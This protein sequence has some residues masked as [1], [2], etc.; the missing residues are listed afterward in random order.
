MFA[1]RQD[2]AFGPVSKRKLLSAYHFR[3]KLV[4][5]LALLA[6]YTTPANSQNCQATSYLPGF[7]P[8]VMQNANGTTVALQADS[9][10]YRRTVH[11]WIDG[12]YYGQ[13]FIPIEV[14][15]GEVEVRLQQGI[16]YETFLGR[17]QTPIRFTPYVIA[18]GAWFGDFR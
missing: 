6:A 7:T 10:D 1:Y 2:N 13:Y 9:H 17:V 11:I 15:A 5:A 8:F 14:I 16:R 18:C 12:I 4:I 3:S